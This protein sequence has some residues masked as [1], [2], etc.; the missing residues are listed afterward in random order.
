MDVVL[1][2]LHYVYVEIRTQ[3]DNGEDFLDDILHRPFEKT[4]PVF[5]DKDEMAFEIPLVPS[6]ALVCIVSQTRLFIR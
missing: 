2:S 1:V 3:F 6:V 5:T 4:F